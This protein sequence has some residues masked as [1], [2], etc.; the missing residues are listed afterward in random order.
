MKLNKTVNKNISNI[1]IQRD[2]TIY[3]TMRVLQNSRMKSL[4]VVSKSNTLLGTITDGDLRRAIL[5][6]KSI[7]KNLNR[8][9]KKN[10]IFFKENQKNINELKEISKREN[11]DL[12]PIV[13]NQKKVIDFYSSLQILSDNKKNK[14][15]SAV[16][17][18]GGQGTRLKPFTDILPKALI[19]LG[20][21]TAI[22]RIIE[23]IQ[24]FNPK[25]FYITINHKSKILKSFF[26]ESNLNIKCNFIYEKTPLG[27]AGS[28]SELKEKKEKTFLVS[29]CDTILNIDFNQIYNY[30]IKNK[31]MI[32][33]IGAFKKFK[34][35]YGRC[36]ADKKG[37]FI[38]IKEK[39]YQHF[40]INTGAYFVE[41]KALN[42]IKKNSFLDFTEFL[43]KAKKKKLKIKI[44]P[45]SDN[46]WIDVGQWDEY[47]K[48]IAHFDY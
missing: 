2:S 1:L 12:I 17:M 3:H 32:T 4:I 25:I 21:K 38:E 34:I 28:L 13:N 35:P 47:K 46:S 15:C 43:M 41:K 20:D 48:N 9:Y 37:T 36:I 44:Y 27:T 30:H 8:V 39:P 5:A 10:C 29:N 22:E 16:I 24:I 18:A 33:I 42:L 19:P 14:N 7:P 23:N 11:I 45:I 40:L 31:N 26:K 6:N